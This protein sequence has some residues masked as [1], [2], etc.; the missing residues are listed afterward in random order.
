MNVLYD[1]LA[2]TIPEKEKRPRINKMKANI[3][4][5]HS[6]TLKTTIMTDIDKNDRIEDETPSLYHIVQARKRRTQRTIQSIEDS[7]G[8][9]H[10]T[11]REI[12][13]V[14]AKHYTHKYGSIDIHEGS[15]HIMLNALHP[16]T[17]DLQTPL[18]D[19]PISMDEIQR[20]LRRGIKKAPGPD[21]IV[22]AFYIE[23]ARSR[24]HRIGILHREL[25]HKTRPM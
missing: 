5:L 6:E 4:K 14:F 15:M 25:G 3:V 21:G 1:I 16:I 22:S 10:H 19:Q 13:N 2:Q 20:A 12:L 7:Q 18:D 24:W 11:P 8:I 9:V 23:S 17:L